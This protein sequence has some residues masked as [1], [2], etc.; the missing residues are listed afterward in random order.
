M[1]ADGYEGIKE[2]KGRQHIYTIAQDEETS[3]IYG[4][5]KAIVEHGMEDEVLPLGKISEG[6]RRKVGVQ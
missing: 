5:P 3:T 4:M 2:L 6:I 1:G